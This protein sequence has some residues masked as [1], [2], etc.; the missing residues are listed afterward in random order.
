MQWAEL[1]VMPALGRRRRLLSLSL[2][3]LKA[4]LRVENFKYWRSLNME[5][6]RVRCTVC[7]RRFTVC[8]TMCC[9]HHVRLIRPVRQTFCASFTM[10]CSDVLQLFVA[11]CVAG[12]SQ[13]VES[14]CGG[15]ACCRKTSSGDSHSCNAGQNGRRQRMSL[16][17]LSRELQ[18]ISDP[19]S[20]ALCLCLSA[21]CQ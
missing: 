1:H 4:V 13:F 14:T 18:A 17:L 6:F 19:Y 16:C 8:C 10:C 7:R 20:R 3:V 11:R 15:G 9:K 12:V 2:T 21:L 5:L